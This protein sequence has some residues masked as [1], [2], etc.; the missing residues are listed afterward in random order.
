MGGDQR[1]AGGVDRLLSY[2]NEISEFCAA[3]RTGKPLRCGP[4]SHRL[5]SRVSLGTRPWKRARVTIG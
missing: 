5:G 4:Q 2:R 3:I 1:A